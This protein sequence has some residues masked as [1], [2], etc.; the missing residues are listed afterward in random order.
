MTYVLSVDGIKEL[1]T[2]GVNIE[3]NVL[4]DSTLK[5]GSGST[6]EEFSINTTLSENS[7]TLVPTQKAV[8]SYIDSLTSEYWNDMQNP[9]GFINT[10]DQVS[11]FTDISLTFSITDSGG[12]SFS[13]YSNS[14]KYTKSTLPETKVIDGSEGIHII[15]YDG[16]T[17]S[18]TSNPTYAQIRD[19]TVNKCIVAWLYWDATNSISIYFTGNNA[20]H[21]INMSGETHFYIRNEIGTQYISGC[22]PVITNID[23]AGGIQAHG[24]FSVG[25]GSMRNAELEVTLTAITDTVATYMYYKDG[26][27]WRRDINNSYASG[28]EFHILTVGGQNTN[29]LINDD[30]TPVQATVTKF[31]MCHVVGIDHFNYQIAT[32]MGNYQYDTALL[33]FSA[34]SSEMNEILQDIPFD[35]IIPIASV[36]FE[37]VSTAVNCNAATR[38]DGSGQEF[39]DWRKS[40]ISKRVIS[41]SHSQLA[42][43]ASDDHLQYYNDTRL[44][45]KTL[46]QIIFSDT[47]TDDKIQFNDNWTI[48]TINASPSDLRIR[49]ADNDQQLIFRTAGSN[50][51]FIRKDPDSLGCQ[52]YNGSKILIQDISFTND[53]I[54]FHDSDGANKIVLRP[55][56]L[57]SNLN[58]IGI[59]SGI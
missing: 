45:D 40:G 4:K 30:G 37:V 17:L 8:K 22:L 14:I 39:V 48:G 47:I 34:A 16:P 42:G 43:L 28:N 54:E 19:I 10:T 44:T 18:A 49:T 27:D 24:R 7:D 1:N 41:S 58:Q 21:G 25:G 53:K 29:P 12:G 57:G 32:V 6:V 50:R 26:S 20:Y 51:L 55:T 3:G 23:G 36:V 59:N 5:I 15:Y 13:Y 52:L 11:S 56:S 2:S 9:N 35:H 38:S 46:E 31:F 33:A